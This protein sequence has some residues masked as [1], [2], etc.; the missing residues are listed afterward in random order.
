[1]ANKVRSDSQK[2][3]EQK[4]N[5]KRLKNPAI[6][7]IRLTAAGAQLLTCRSGLY[8]ERRLVRVSSKP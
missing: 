8:T 4:Y 7:A 6:P 5:E 2:K 1:M 3:A